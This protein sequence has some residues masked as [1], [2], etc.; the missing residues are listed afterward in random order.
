MFM[1]HQI[2]SSLLNS[3]FMQKEQ[4]DLFDNGKIYVFYARSESGEDLKLFSSISY[5]AS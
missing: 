4:K 1:Q 2:R 3:K 5:F